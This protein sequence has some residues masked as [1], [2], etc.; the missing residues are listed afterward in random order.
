VII[1]PSTRI[2]NFGIGCLTYLKSASNRLNERLQREKCVAHNTARILPESSIVNSLGCK[3]AI[4]IG[5]HTVSRGEFR[6]FN[7]AGSIRIGCYCYIG[8][9]SRIWSAVGITIGDRVLISHFVNIHDNDSHPKSASLR[10]RQ[11]IEIFEK[12]AFDMT[13]VGM[14]PIV[15]EDD[16]WIGFNASVMKGVTVGKGAVIGAAT[17]ITKD[18]PPYAIMVGNPARLVGTA[19]E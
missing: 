19:S 2:L 17:V 14:A 10:H 13:D 4:K 12:P 7:P 3:E 15:I 11:A 5:A 8:D 9:H 6:I 16:V 18:V 1:G